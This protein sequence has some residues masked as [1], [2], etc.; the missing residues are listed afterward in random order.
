[1]ILNGLLSKPQDE[2]VIRALAVIKHGADV[3]LLHNDLALACRVRGNYT[4]NVVQLR[5]LQLPVD[6]PQPS[7]AFPCLASL[8]SETCHIKA[9]QLDMRNNFTRTFSEDFY[10]P[11]K[12]SCHFIP[13]F[14]E[15][16]PRTYFCQACIVYWSLIHS[17]VSQ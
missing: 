4:C 3:N 12:T 16:Q 6:T 8:Y 15:P 14:A 7:D 11:L 1:M 10:L 9:Y 5:H 13:H 2:T 17:D